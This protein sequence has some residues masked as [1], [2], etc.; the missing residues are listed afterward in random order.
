VISDN[1]VTN[2]WRQEWSN[3]ER[4]VSGSTLNIDVLCVNVI[5]CACLWGM[6]CVQKYSTLQWSKPDGHPE[7]GRNNYKA[8]G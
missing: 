2:L 3:A 1:S 5:Y 8:F 7:A 4:P 6:Q